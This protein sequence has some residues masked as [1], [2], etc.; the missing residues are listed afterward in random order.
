MEKYDK[1]SE[2]PLI[3]KVLKGCLTIFH[4]TASV[5]GAINTTSNTLGDRSH[6]MTDEMLS[7]RKLVKSAVKGASI[8]CCIDFMLEDEKYFDNWKK[9]VTQP[10]LDLM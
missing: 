9:V 8:K 4:T 7:S 6:S 5:E 1:S 3:S 2:F 10:C